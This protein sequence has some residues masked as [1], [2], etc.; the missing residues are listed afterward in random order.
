MAV[1]GVARTA[2]PAARDGILSSAGDGT[3]PG[4]I[5]RHE[6]GR[7]TSRIGGPQEVT[8]R[9]SRTCRVDI[10]RAAECFGIVD[11]DGS[12]IDAEA[13][14]ARLVWNG[15]MQLRGRKHQDA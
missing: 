4:L 12:E 13:S 8:E 5:G 10:W 15:R 3:R 1:N 9:T 7:H 2:M 6:L 11:V 14:A